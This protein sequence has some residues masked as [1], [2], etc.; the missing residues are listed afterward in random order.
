MCCRWHYGSWRWGRGPFL[1]INND[2]YLL[3]LS[4]QTIHVHHK[5]LSDILT[6]LIQYCELGIQDHLPDHVVSECHV[7]HQ[8]ACRVDFL[9]TLIERNLHGCG[10][11]VYR[12]EVAFQYDHRDKELHIEVTFILGLV[13]ELLSFLFAAHILHQ[14]ITFLVVVLEGD[15][16]LLSFL[17]L[18]NL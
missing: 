6:S 15:V 4:V 1:K 16:F 3:N 7:R 11:K 13:L 5:T 18:T 10:D 12:N 17:L 8:D 2:D 9:D 14:H